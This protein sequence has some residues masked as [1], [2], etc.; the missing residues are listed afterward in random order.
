VELGILGPIEVR[1][2]GAAV[3][4]RGAKPRQLLALFAIRP[5]Q[6][7]AADQ[8][9]D[10]LWQGHPPPSAATALRVHIRH[11]RQVLDVGREPSA[12]SVRLPASPH[13]YL[14]RVQPD[15][16]DASRFERLVALGRDAIAAGDP[17]QAVVELSAALGLWRGEVLADV[18]DL[19]AAHAT[20]S[21]LD[22]LGVAAT[23][24]LA[25]THLALGEHA[26]VVD[27][28]RPAVERYPFR[29]R[30]TAS[31]IR[32]LYRSG[33]QADALHVYADLARRLDDDLGTAPS[34]EL[35]QLEEDVLLQRPSLN[36]V[37]TPTPSRPAIPTQSP[38]VRFIGRRH[39]LGRLVDAFVAAAQE[40]SRLILVT[41]E[42]GI[43]KTTLT[44]ELCARA[45]ELGADPVIGHCDA[46]STVNYQP[47]VEILRT[48]VGRLKTEDR[49]S[50]P[51]SLALL[52]PEL[53]DVTGADDADG[54]T[55]A[56]AAQFRLFEAMATTCA[57]LGDRPILMVIEDLHW[58]D[59]PTLRAIRHLLLHPTLDR[60]LVVATCRDDE[61]DG[62]AAE[63]INRLATSAPSTKLAIFG[64]D[65]HE[66]RALVRAAAPR[67]TKDTLIDLAATLQDATGGNP[68]FL[69]EL[70]S[71]FD[72]HWL[73]VDDASVAAM[74]SRLAPLGVRALVDRR[75]NR[76]TGAAR[77]VVCAASVLGADL[78]VAILAAVC[79]VPP[80]VTYQAL[81]E[82]LVARL[83][84][85]DGRH[86][87]RY[88]FRHA[89]LRN[90]VYETIP[91]A[92][93]RALHR[94]VADILERTEP[95]DR[96]ARN[97]QL[98]Y[99]YGAAAPLGLAREAAEYAE[100]AGHDA[101]AQFAYAEA[102]RW[103][104]EAVKFRTALG[105]PDPAMGRL[106]LVFGQALSNDKQPGP[107][108]ERLLAAA[109]CAR[110]SNDRSL[111]AEV[112]VAADD[113]WALGADFQPEVLSL[114]EEAL[115]RLDPDAIDQ[116]VQIL[117]RI[118][119]DL[120]Y[121]DAEREGRVAHEALS[122]AERG[123]NPTAL[124]TAQMAV[125]LWQT[126]QPEAAP[127]RLV[128]G[129]SAY[130]LAQRGR[131]LSDTHLL[132]H[133]A[134]LA[135]LLENSQITEF[136][137]SLD[138]YEHA[139]RHLG[140]PR[141]IY[142]SAAL[143]ATQ[144]TLHGDLAAGEQLARGAAL[145][146]HELEQF[147]D[148]AFLLQRF[149]IRYHQNRLSE[150]VP[151][152]KQVGRAR[153]VYRAGGALAAVAY[154]ETGQTDRALA[155]AWDTLGRDGSAL[156]RDAFWLAATALLAGVASVTN[157]PLLSELLHPMLEPC[158]E[159][160]VVFGA[161]AAVLGAVHHWL[162]LLAAARSQTDVA[163]DHFV[164]AIT[165]AQHL[166]APY[167]IAQ[168]TMNLACA[169]QVQGRP[170]DTVRIAQLV[171]SATD[172]ATRHGYGRVLAHAP[173]LQP[174]SR[175]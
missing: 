110:Q 149:V 166:A 112:A 10:E 50:L 22:D 57:R 53:I 109:V 70:L 146:G 86:L 15:E 135:D 150:E 105:T 21:R 134:L 130:E 114:L 136:A 85:E 19:A 25:E 148:G 157:D 20:I 173:T 171:A 26:R 48:V 78:T 142:W 31:L 37:P 113:P 46:E 43:G 11:L 63:A 153:S 133:R 94:R 40:P 80:D 65:D 144:T 104:G 71:E 115:D 69:R 163:A 91:T 117:T 29:E 167:W 111:L 119:S 123:E 3:P 6:S 120:Y 99:H 67:E 36:F 127:Q 14:L 172:L 17:R 139:A 160:V 72:E 89:L 107:A 1:Q 34:Q 74:L 98:A 45:R 55:P 27:L 5:N 84:I 162:G 96:T 87:H 56:P 125:H 95:T 4:V 154:A 121:V 47:I 151:I 41:G 82:G 83:L 49:V 59:R 164:Q 44:Q 51:P 145:R 124:A 152:L 24:D 28:V 102:V 18:G 54:A 60:M 169:L 158:A 9:I 122:I 106:Y 79:D 16:L 132:T 161:G 155:A 76:L 62:D 12:A 100:L 39:E 101:R 97:A 129:R 128:L 66:V 131:H 137:D 58:A 7:I 165:V 30:L 126:H 38:V 147:S 61:I 108:R 42:A 118:A 88:Q 138:G 156:P 90:G 13:G 8:L 33:R 170:G 64:F 168:A 35:R 81:D 143:R 92:S 174:T 141:D 77:D 103:Y 93:R 68:L 73:N 175:T 159:L 116:R 75:L 52:V 140:S 32:G 23:E 2:D